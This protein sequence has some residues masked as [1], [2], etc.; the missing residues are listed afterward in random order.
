LHIYA[1]GNVEK[2]LAKKTIYSG[3]ESHRIFNEQYCTSRDAMAVN[4]LTPNLMTEDLAATVDW[5][6]RLLDAEVVT[7]LP[8]D[9][10]RENGWWAQLRLDDASLMFQERGS[11]IEKIPALEGEP[12]G[13]SIACYVD[14]DD[15]ERLHDRLTGAGVELAQPLHETEF[16]WRQFAVVDPNGYVL[17]FGEKLDSQES[18]DMG[19]RQRA[20]VR[21][22]HS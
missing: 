11:L 21:R 2:K 17:W 8:P 7:T 18:I 19:R 3:I 10:G 16:G 9:S 1:R 22:F 14:V 12:V 4:S 6:E 15:A 20:L 5:Y 13:G